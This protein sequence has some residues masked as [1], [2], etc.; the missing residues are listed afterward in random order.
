M[1][2]MDNTQLKAVKKFRS[3]KN[4]IKQYNIFNSYQEWQR[5][6]ILAYYINVK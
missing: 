1:K 3:A 4:E 5:S 2:D 6:K